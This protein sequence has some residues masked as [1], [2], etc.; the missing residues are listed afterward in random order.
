MFQ[1]PT[2]VMDLERLLR[3][4]LHLVVDLPERPAGFRGYCQWV[5]PIPEKDG[6]KGSPRKVRFLSSVEWSWSPMNSRWDGYFLN[7]R[8]KY[9]LLWFRYLDDDAWNPKWRW[10][11]YAWGLRKGVSEKAAA[12]YLLADAWSSEVRYYD[13]DHFHLINDTG[14][15]SLPELCAVARLVWPD[16]AFDGDGEALAMSDGE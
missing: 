2:I 5:D 6:P 8:G 9:W 15:L 13:L 7:P 10:E 4:R 12:I 11:F 14:L 1:E 16:V 3:Q